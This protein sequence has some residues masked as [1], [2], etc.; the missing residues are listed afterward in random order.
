MRTAQKR[1]S[2][3]ALGGVRIYSCQVIHYSLLL[4]APRFRLLFLRCCTCETP[5]ENKH[6]DTRLGSYVYCGDA[7]SFH[8]LEF[9]TRF[10]VAATTGDHYLEAVS[11]VCDG[12]RG[13]AF[14]AAEE[15]GFDSLFEI[16]KGTPRGIDTPTRHMREMAFPLTE[17]ESEELFRQ[18]CRPGRPLSRQQGELM[19]QF[20]SRRRRCWTW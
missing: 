6:T 4:P 13:D 9:R 14:I 10:R 19:K 8:E 11:M 17:R 1:D 3:L 15:V 5:L 16:V 18:Y 12:L 7:A 20:V 2:L